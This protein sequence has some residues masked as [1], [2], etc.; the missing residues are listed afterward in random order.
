MRHNRKKSTFGRKRAQRKA[1]LRNLCDSLILNGKIRTTKAKA[2]TLR[3]VIEPLVTKAKRGSV[4]DRRAVKK[5]LYTKKALTTLM[6]VIAPQ[7]KDRQGGYTR[8]TPA[9]HRVN[10][11]ADMVYIEFV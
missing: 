11:G 6:D 1:L 10:D 4:A 2:K 9:G 3:T 5:G 8:I 7:Y